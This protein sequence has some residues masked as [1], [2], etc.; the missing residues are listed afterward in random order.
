[1]IASLHLA[2][3]RT[4]HCRFRVEHGHYGVRLAFEWPSGVEA[5]TVTGWTLDSAL[6]MYA[7]LG[8]GDT[9]S[10]DIPPSYLGAL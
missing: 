6:A 7:P 2:D 3:G 9:L 5:G 8:E 1:M 10:I 4:V